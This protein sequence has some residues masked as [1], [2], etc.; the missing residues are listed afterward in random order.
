[1]VCLDSQN[2]IWSSL[3]KSR[4][5]GHIAINYWQWYMHMFMLCIDAKY[6]IIGLLLHRK[7]KNNQKLWINFWLFA[8]S[9]QK[10][11]IRINKIIN[12]VIISH[13]ELSNITKRNVA[14]S[15]LIKQMLKNISLANVAK[16]TCQWRFQWIQ[17][18][19]ITI[20]FEIW[21]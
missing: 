9:L 2:S 1:M 6:K 10:Y 4:K 3:P 18:I 14:I 7:T 19:A 15:S 12:N 13:W 16:L 11:L 21:L 17:F 5:E 20:A 8:N